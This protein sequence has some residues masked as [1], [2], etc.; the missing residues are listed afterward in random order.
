MSQLPKGVQKLVLCSWIY[1]ILSFLSSL[2]M[3]VFFPPEVLDVLLCSF[4]SVLPI[5]WCAVL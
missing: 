1:L 5:C 3:E 2:E 4:A